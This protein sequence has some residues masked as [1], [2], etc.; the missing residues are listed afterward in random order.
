MN[1]TELIHEVSNVFDEV[2]R[3][4]RSVETSLAQGMM[5][6]EIEDGEFSQMPA[7]NGPGHYSL[8]ESASNS[9]SKITAHG[10]ENARLEDVITKDTYERILKKI[11]SRK[12]LG[13]GLAVD[14]KN[15]TRAI[16]ETGRECS[17]ILSK[18][19]HIIPV[20][21]I[22]Q[23]TPNCFKLGPITFINR[24]EFELF[25]SR[26]SDNVEYEKRHDENQEDLDYLLNSSL[27]YYRSFKWFAC[28]E[29]NQSEDTIS[30]EI[31]EECAKDALSFL[32]VLFSEYYSE[33]FEVGGMSIT[34]DRRAKISLREGK[35]Y[36]SLSYADVEN[37]GFSEGWEKKYIYAEDSAELIKHA[38]QIIDLKC[39]FQKPNM[40]ARRLSAAIDWFSQGVTE[41]SDAAAIVKYVTG[42]ETLFMPKKTSGISIVLSERLAAFCH[43]PDEAGSYQKALD[44][45]K[46]LY[47]LRSRAVHG[48]LVPSRHREFSN[49][50]YKTSEMS[51]I[52]II[53][54]M[55]AV[56]TKGL[57]DANIGIR[58]Y[59][60]YL[61]QYTVFMKN[62]IHNPTDES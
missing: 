21:F 31:A 37:G 19:I 55:R 23:N 4:S 40:I 15:V 47:K 59:E 25:A 17:K 1:H 7:P 18:H 41:K 48:N 44:D 3:V 20:K 11:L 42:L 62:Y 38:G 33:K 13:E 46:D 51:R 26:L 61:D 9:I 43:F 45:A 54:F 12:F 50:R 10:M 28:I 6:Q 57:K 36:P 39:R 2:R 16:G 53:Q 58:R 32:Q 8:S 30:R 56:G 49:G 14:Q 27:K 34:Y 60:I 35:F 5:L 22:N 29:I 52:A 24:S